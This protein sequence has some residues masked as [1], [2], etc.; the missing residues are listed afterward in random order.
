MNLFAERY[1]VTDFP[2]PDQVALMAA[3]ETARHA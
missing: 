2:N 1:L 3:P